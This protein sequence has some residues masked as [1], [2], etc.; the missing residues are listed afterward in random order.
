MIAPSRKQIVWYSLALLGLAGGLDAL[1]RWW[2]FGYVFERFGVGLRKEQFYY[3]SRE[4]R[5][6]PSFGF[7]VAD[8]DDVNIV[9][10]RSG[11]LESHWDQVGVRP[12]LASLSVTGLVGLGLTKIAASTRGRRRRR[13]RLTLATFTLGTGIL[14]LVSENGRWVYLRDHVYIVLTGGCVEA[15]IAADSSRFDVLRQSRPGIDFIMLSFSDHTRI[16]HMRL[17][18]SAPN[19]KL[20]LWIPFLLGLSSL[21]AVRSRVPR[22][23]HDRCSECDYDLTGNVSGVCPECG[24][25]IQAVA[26]SS[27]AGPPPVE[28]PANP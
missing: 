21:V 17:S 9:I 20:P 22:G 7:Y 5:V 24:T 15:V 23:D 18:R 4:E 8:A 25:R 28:N 10:G 1:S 13:L 12:W 16:P 26:T 3:F 27:E 11:G 6:S 2:Q 14:W 19:G